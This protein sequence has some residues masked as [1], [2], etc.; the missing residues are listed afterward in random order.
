MSPLESAQE[1]IL[2]GIQKL[3]CGA[4]PGPIPRTET[5]EKLPYGRF[6]FV[7]WPKSGRR[8]NLKQWLTTESAK[9]SEETT[10]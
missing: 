3:E 9:P 2:E 5:K 7:Q 1:G 8:E 10:A 6:S 4:H